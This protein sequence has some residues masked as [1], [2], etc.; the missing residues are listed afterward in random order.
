[1]IWVFCFVFWFFVAESPNSTGFVSERDGGLRN[2]LEF[3]FRF[4]SLGYGYM[5]KGERGEL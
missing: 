3:A 4:F 1:M 5:Q 2:G